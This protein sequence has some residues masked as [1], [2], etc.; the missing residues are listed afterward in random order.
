MDV[1]K[2]L[3]LTGRGHYGPFGF[4]FHFFV[5]RTMASA[6]LVNLE[7]ISESES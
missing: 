7:F 2:V 1:P 4:Q 5:K 6:W 3:S